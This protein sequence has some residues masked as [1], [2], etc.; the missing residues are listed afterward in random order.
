M[1]HEINFTCGF[2]LALLWYHLIVRPFFA[3]DG[4]NVQAGIEVASQLVSEN[5]AE[6]SNSALFLFFTG[7]I[8]RLKVMQPLSI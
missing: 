3:L 8:H 6:Y 2:R 7:R 5:K 1:V 4:S